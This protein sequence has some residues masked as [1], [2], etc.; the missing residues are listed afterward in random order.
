MD[1]F[2]CTNGAF[3]IISDGQDDVLGSG[4]VDNVFGDHFMVYYR[5]ALDVEGK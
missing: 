1:L 2:N 4:E 3:Y 5:T